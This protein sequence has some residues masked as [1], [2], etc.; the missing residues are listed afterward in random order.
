MTGNYPDL[1]GKTVVV[2]G[3]SRG[4]GARTAR[5]FA[6]QGAKVCVVGRDEAALAA[7]L[8]DL[9]DS[10]LSVA[11]DVTSSAALEGV[12]REV[13]SRLGPV[14]VLAAFAGGQG[15]PSRRPN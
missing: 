7:V 13:E 4:I 1:A 2:T 11:A 8:A 9:G 12:R 14:D 10:A 6:A 15:F 3:G 5:A